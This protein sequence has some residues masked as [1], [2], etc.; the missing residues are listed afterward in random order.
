VCD[1]ASSANTPCVAAFSMTRALYA[2]YTGPLYA[3]RKSS[4][5]V[6]TLDVL[7][8]SDGLAHVRV[9]HEFCD[10]A[11][12]QVIKIYDQ[13]PNGNHLNIAPPGGAAPFTDTGVFADRAPVIVNGTELFGAYFEGG[14]GYR[15]IDTK[16]IP[17]GDEPETMYMLTRG[18]HYNDGCCFDF[19]NA[20]VDSHDDGKGTMEAVY[21]GNSNGWGRGAGDGPWV[22]A[23]LENGLWAGDNQTNPENKPV[24][25]TF[26]TAML[27]GKPK[28]FSLKSGDAQDTSSF[29]T[30]YEGP[31]PPGYE[32]MNKQGSIILGIGGDNSDR[33]IGTFYE[34]VMIGN[35]T[36]DSTDAAIHANIAAM[37]Y[38][39][40]YN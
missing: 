9:Q 12:C 35:W 11:E 15:N 34:G 23:D 5:T 39:A 22:M 14:M 7:V 25:A 38:A 27:K 2:S 28:S 6:E 8:A 37:K 18:D 31:R 4:D 30:I 1:I 19:G 24:T 20:E 10:G 3:L 13:S 33:A 32:V 40:K 36:D 26:V 17:T 29:K 21:F 16:N